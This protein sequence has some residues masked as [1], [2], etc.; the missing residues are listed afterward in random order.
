[1][2]GRKRR[3]RKGLLYG[4]IR[5]PDS[6]R[7]ASF[8]RS[9]P[10]FCSFSLFFFHLDQRSFLPARSN[11]DYGCLANYFQSTSAAILEMYG[12]IDRISSV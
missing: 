4:S 7:V 12:C 10:F 5:D 11:N 3:I 8:A 6:L 1:M 2:K 9:S